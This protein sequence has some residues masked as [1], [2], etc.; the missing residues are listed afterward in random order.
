MNL[1][2]IIRLNP[3]QLQH[4][5]YFLQGDKTEALLSELNTVFIKIKVAYLRY[6]LMYQICGATVL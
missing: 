2:C 5:E 3:M 6:L 1:V 4:C